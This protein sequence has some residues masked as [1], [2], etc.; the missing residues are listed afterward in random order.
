MK[1][2]FYDI[3]YALKA[4]LTHGLEIMEALKYFFIDYDY[5]PLYSEIDEYL[6][7]TLN[8]APTITN[9]LFI[10][11]KSWW[12]KSGLMNIVISIKANKEI[13]L[14]DWG[15]ITFILK[16]DTRHRYKNAH[17]KTTG[18]QIHKDGKTVLRL[19]PLNLLNNKAA[20]K[21]FKV[22]EDILAVSVKLDTGRIKSLDPEGVP[23]LELVLISGQL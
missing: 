10:S 4:V 22:K 5:A 7:K 2:L 13:G 8:Q 20:K 21:L 12:R 9:D 15:K 18:H 1:T 16:G 11:E 19:A 17:F 3:L 23:I 6:F 14:L